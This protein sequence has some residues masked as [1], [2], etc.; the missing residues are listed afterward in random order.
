M[1]KCRTCGKIYKHRQTLYNHARYECG[2]EP[3][4]QCEYCP[5]NGCVEVHIEEND[6]C[7]MKEEML[8]YLFLIYF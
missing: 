2:K 7:K 3:S 5:Y 1:Y 6:C 4:F 8:R